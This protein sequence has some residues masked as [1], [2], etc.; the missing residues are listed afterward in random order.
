MEVLPTDPM[1]TVEANL[2][3]AYIYL[4]F[5]VFR[6]ALSLLNLGVILFSVYF[7]ITGKDLFGNKFDTHQALIIFISTG[8]IAV[9][10]LGIVNAFWWGKLKE[11]LNIAVSYAICI[12]VLICGALIAGLFSSDISGADILF[13]VLVT[14]CSGL[15]FVISWSFAFCVYKAKRFAKLKK[16]GLKGLKQIEKLNK[17]GFTI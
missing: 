6:V 16:K 11:H 4:A 5:K 13:I 14:L 12:T 1:K 15:L 3:I 17:I 9:A 10:F 7:S 8:V 2:D